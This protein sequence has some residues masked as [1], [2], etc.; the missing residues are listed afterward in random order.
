MKKV[1]LVEDEE[2]ILQGIR[3]II[4][5][6][7]L[8][9]SVVHM[10]H[11]GEEALSLWK[12]EPVDIIV[13]DLEMPVMGGLEL[14]RTIRQ[15]DERV[16]FIILT[17]YDEF[18]YAREAIRLEVENYLLKPIDEEELIA[19][20]KE[21]IQKLDEIDKAKHQYTNQKNNWLQFLSGKL[22]EPEKE[23]IIELLEHSVDSP[24]SYAAIIKLNLESMKDIKLTDV[25]VKIREEKEK[26]IV[27]H[28][29]VESMFIM[30]SGERISQQEALEYFKGLQDRLESSLGVM[31]FITLGTP[32]H[33]FRDL[34]ACY[35]SAKKLQKYL[36]LEGYGSCLDQNSFRRRKTK[37]IAVDSVYLRKLVLKKDRTGVIDYLS[38][39]FLNNIGE[40]SDVDALYQ[41]A[42]KI[43]M[44]L[45]EIK[46]EYKL[47]ESGNLQ[48]LTELIES[49]YQAE[50]VFGLKAIFTSEIDEII[51]NL[52]EEDSHYTP[53]VKQIIHEV[54]KNY[55]D[56]M[57]LKTLA[58][59]YHMNASYLGQIFQKEVGVS[60]AS[61][62]S[63]TKMGIAKDLI[64]NTNMKIN[65]I[66]REVGYPDTSYFYRKFKQCFGV[67]PA[68]LREMKKY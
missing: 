34:P 20:L 28:L 43:A 23:E 9:L 57:N 4:D 27:L 35:K 16:K 38:D 55:K 52:H 67:S 30:W 37:D 62:L 15:E 26:L 22:R 33:S 54:M 48:A 58:Y 41:V 8:G 63:S 47:E 40:D 65:D 12:K 39:L 60:F 17:G 61:Y 13:T 45:Q 10:A 29:D 3:N 31:T 42:I 5:W 14:L 32:C 24:L 25:L 46:E 53:V 44:I 21:T 66:A 18:A 50:T 64:L 56:D 1:M 51:N 68:S 2:L 6:E 11:H 36:I 49:I 7:E 59:K 19:Q